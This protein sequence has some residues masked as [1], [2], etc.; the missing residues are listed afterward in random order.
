MAKDIA[1]GWLDELADFLESYAAENSAATEK[2][3]SAKG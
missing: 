1:E 3:E 2:I